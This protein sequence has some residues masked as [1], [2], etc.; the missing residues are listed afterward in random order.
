MLVSNSSNGT[1][2]NENKLVKNEV[3]ELKHEARIS[4][5][6]TDLELFWFLDE[7]AMRE[8]QRYPKDIS[9]HFA[10]GNIVG[11]GTF[12]KVRKGFLKKEGTPVALKFVDKNKL[13][14]TFQYSEQDLVAI[15]SEVEI[16][17]NLHHILRV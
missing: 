17:S 3:A 4:V 13:R 11:S 6:G 1:Y 12:A 10:I 9:K 15:K 8:N 16:L 5:L 7:K 14:W 2:V